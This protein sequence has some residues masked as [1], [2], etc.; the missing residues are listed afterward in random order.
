MREQTAIPPRASRTTLQQSVQPALDVEEDESYYPKRLPSSARRYT[1]SQGNQVIQQG[2][3]RIVIHNEPPPVKRRHWLLPL[4]SGMLV[5]LA[6]F[7]L[8]SWLVTWWTNHQLD[9]TYGYPR[10]WQTDEV[11]GHA[12]STSHPSHFLFENLKGHIIMIELPGGDV[13][14]A[15]IYSGPTLFSDNADT[16]PVTGEFK[17]VNG[18]GKVDMLLHIQDQTIVYLNDGTQFK[19]QQ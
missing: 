4:G 6:L 14:H 5:M 1:T 11:V 2:N 8:G 17:D 9:S 12:D 7:L 19:P 13:Q 10:T 3:R 18:D 15:R 16:V